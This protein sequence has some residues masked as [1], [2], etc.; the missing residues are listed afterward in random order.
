MRAFDW[1]WPWMA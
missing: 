1:W